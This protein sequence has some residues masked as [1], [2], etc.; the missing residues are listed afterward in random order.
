M[1]D[2]EREGRE[3]TGP[4]FH[5]SVQGMGPEPAEAGDPEEMEADMDTEAGW[6]GDHNPRTLSPPNVQKVW[7]N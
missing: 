3:P 4:N 1:E 5:L 6:G 7:Y 2:A